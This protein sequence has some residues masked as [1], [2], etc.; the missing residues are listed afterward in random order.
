MQHTAPSGLRRIWRPF[1][2]AAVAAV[3]AISMGIGATTAMA[4]SQDITS[5]HI[6]VVSLNYDGTGIELGSNY[7]DTAWKPASTYDLVVPWTTGASGTGYIIPQTHAEA[8]S[9]N[10]PWA[11]FS[12]DES[13]RD[14]LTNNDTVTVTLTGVQFTAKQGESNAPNGNVTVSQNGQVWFDQQGGSHSFAVTAGDDEVF[15]EHVKWVF[16]RAGTYNL[17]FESHTSNG[18][19]ASPQTYTFKVGL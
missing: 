18:Y 13:L 12:G 15:H 1:V 10:V 11:G 9:R 3:A 19:V 8:I 17:T 4:A 7:E 6:D 5:G 2:G 16:S 14:I